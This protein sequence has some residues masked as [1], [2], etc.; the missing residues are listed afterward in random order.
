M[1]EL[2][3]VSTENVCRIKDK[4]SNREEF[5]IVISTQRI[6]IVGGFKRI[7]RLI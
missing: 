5:P 3:L 2:F 1:I 7:F 6:L 4:E